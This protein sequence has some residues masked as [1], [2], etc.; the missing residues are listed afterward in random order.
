MAL[1]KSAT[2]IENEFVS[3]VPKVTGVVKASS[4]DIST[5][6]EEL[7]LISSFQ[8]IVKAAFVG[9]LKFKKMLLTA[10]SCSTKAGSGDVIVILSSVSQADV[11]SRNESR[12]KLI[13][14]INIFIFLVFIS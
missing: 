11:R 5:V 3:D 1:L 6:Y 2:D 9:K 12:I 8:D 14:L 13:F 10:G 7:P 4:V